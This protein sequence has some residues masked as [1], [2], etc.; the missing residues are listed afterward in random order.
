MIVVFMCSNRESMS[1][2]TESN[3]YYYTHVFFYTLQIVNLEFQKK[4]IYICFFIFNKKK[5]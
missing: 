5:L 2:F 3:L 1:F 4:N